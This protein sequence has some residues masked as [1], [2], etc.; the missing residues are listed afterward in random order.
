[1]TRNRRTS[2]KKDPDSSLRN[3]IYILSK[4]NTVF[5]DL[6]VVLGAGREACKTINS[7]TYIFEDKKMNL[8]KKWF[9]SAVIYF[10]RERT[11]FEMLFPVLFSRPKLQKLRG[12]TVFFRA[13][14]T[15]NFQNRYLPPFM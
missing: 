7:S 15:R 12:K 13:D 6:R 8:K 5:A 10:V 3:V 4:C 2:F 1:M 14:S 11:F 9:T